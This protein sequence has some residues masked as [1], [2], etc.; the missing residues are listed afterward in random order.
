M[1]SC[2][3]LIE[4]SEFTFTFN[5]WHYIVFNTIHGKHFKVTIN[6]ILH[7][8]NLA[9]N[10]Y[11]NHLF[12]RHDNS[13][14]ESS[15]EKVQLQTWY[16]CYGTCVVIITTYVGWLDH[17]HNPIH[18]QTSFIE[19]NIW[20]SSHSTG[21]WVVRCDIGFSSA[22]RYV[23]YTSTTIPSEAYHG[24]YVSIYAMETNITW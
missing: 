21:S 12:Y 20:T 10:M 11:I 1:F 8:V 9:L 15:L 17:P 7:S 23:V 4:S 16:S 19:T 6:H 22:W 14:L 18:K 2:V 13:V 3:S 5:L 24:S